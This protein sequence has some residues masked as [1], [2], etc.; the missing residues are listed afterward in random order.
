MNRFRKTLVTLT[1]LAYTEFFGLIN[2]DEEMR[3]AGGMK[4]YDIFTFIIII[5]LVYLLFNSKIFKTDLLTKNRTQKFIGAYLLLVL[6]VAISMKFR[7]PVTLLDTFKIARNFFP[8]FI[9]YYVWYDI[10]VSGSLAYYESLLKVIAIG[11]SIIF[12]ITTVA[13]D[14]IR[15]VFH[16]LNVKMQTSTGFKMPRTYGYGFVFPYL[17]FI[18][19]YI[20]YFLSKKINLLTFFITFI[21][22]S[23]QG[24][25]SYFFALIIL[26]FMINILFADRQTIINSLVGLGILVAV[27]G[28]TGAIIGGNFFADK[29]MS[30]FSEVSSEEGS[31]AGRELSDLIFRLPL[32]LKNIYF[33]IGFVHGESKYAMSLG[34]VYKDRDYMLYSTDSGLVTMSL[35]FGVIGAALIGVLVLKY[36]YYLFKIARKSKNIRLKKYVITAFSYMAL[37]LITIKT[38]GGLIYIY[39]LTPMV[40]ILGMLAGYDSL[41]KLNTQQKPVADPN[42]INLYVQPSLALK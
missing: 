13:P 5:H 20:N 35:M 2:A 38:H 32:L 39:G 41:L 16:G 6:S 24:F 40:C 33:G 21:G 12:I 26:V 30:I 17:F 1:I 34:S 7:A 31:Y 8:L 42:N 37:L 3:I 11:F 15:S 19:Q 9:F 22:V 10:V 23:V 25:R 14:F 29:V 36:M 18:Y 28:V 4:I 27:T